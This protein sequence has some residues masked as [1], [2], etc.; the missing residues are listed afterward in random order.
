MSALNPI[1]FPFIEL[2]RVDSTNNYAMGLVHAGM[3]QHGIAVFSHHQT[4]GRGQYNK[5][6]IS[7]AQSNIAISVVL[8]PPLSTSQIFFVSKMVATAVLRFLSR[9]AIGNTSIKWPNDIYWC[10]RKAG[11][12]LIEN[13]I[14]GAEWKYSVVGIGI[15]INQTDFGDLK[16]KAVSLKQITGNNFDPVSLAKEICDILDTQFDQLTLDP[17]AV[18]KEYRSNLYKL[19][20]KIKLKKGNRIFEAIM[21]DVT[22]TGQLIVQHAVDER[23]DVGEVEWM[24]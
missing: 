15:N 21:K 3:A 19:G 11:G 8:E 23:F 5:D 16:N 20:E 6:W 7:E 18:I 24:L 2:H 17:N 14:Q 1:G 12:I 13:V 9:Y 4:K 22:D 10:D